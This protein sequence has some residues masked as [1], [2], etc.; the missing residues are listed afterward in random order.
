M[1]TL[2]QAEGGAEAA[3]AAPQGL[4]RRPPMPPAAASPPG[5]GQGARSARATPPAWEYEIRGTP[6]RSARGSLPVL[7]E[8]EE[9]GGPPIGG[10][11]IRA[12][13]R[14]QLR[15]G[16]AGAGGGAK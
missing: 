10:D 2:L 11:P 7:Q 3:G 6:P 15:R 12:A 5:A 14:E 9:G 1:P 13:L 16:G 4:M 8:G